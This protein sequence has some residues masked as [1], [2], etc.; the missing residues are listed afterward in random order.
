MPRTHYFLAGIIYFF[1]SIFN[2]FASLRESTTHYNNAYSFPPGSAPIALVKPSRVLDLEFFHLH[3]LDL[4]PGCARETILPA[5]KEIATPPPLPNM[6]PA[7]DFNR[8]GFVYIKVLGMVNQV[9]PYTR[10]W[11]PL[12]TAVSYLVR[13]A[14]IVYMAFQAQPASPG[15]VQPDSDGVF[16]MEYP[17]T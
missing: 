14:P 17:T 4:P 7:H 3:H 8:L 13:I 11:H 9:V 1:S 6:P 15:G 12:T 5:M 2:L 16:E 10:S